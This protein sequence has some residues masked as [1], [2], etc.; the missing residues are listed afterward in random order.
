M[1]GIFLAGGIGAMSAPL[2]WMLLTAFTRESALYDLT[3]WPLTPHDFT[4]QN[5]TRLFATT[6]MMRWTINSVLLASMSAFITIVVAFPAAYAV[7][8]INSPHARI[9]GST[10]IL[11]YALPPSLLVIPLFT[12]AARI[13]LYDSPMLLVIVYAAMA[14]P[15][16]TWLLVQYVG[17]IPQSV[18]DI[19]RLDG[20]RTPQLLIGVIL[21]ATRGGIAIT[22]VF[23]F[24]LAW[25]EY[26]YA[27]TL[28]SSPEHKTIPVGI[29]LLQGGD[30]YNWGM[31]MAG[32]AIASLPAL[33]IVGIIRGALRLVAPQHT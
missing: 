16:A 9:F 22:Y 4:T 25:G 21:P 13:G 23:S 6:G 19:A 20:C 29:A 31:M 33:A 10:L 11:A 2:L 15:I 7:A 17:Q 27:L 28:M 12:I 1:P 30:I 8:R 26:I 14:T 32:A 5:V 3:R 24:L 18:D